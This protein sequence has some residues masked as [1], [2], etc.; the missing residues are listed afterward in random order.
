MERTTLF[1][2]QLIKSEICGKPISAELR[3]SIGTDDVEKLYSLSKKH[4]M[5]HLV[6]SALEHAELTFDSEYA[7]KLKIQ[8]LLATFRYAQFAH[9]FRSLC[10]VLEEAGIQ[11]IPLKGSVMRSYYPEPWMRTSCDIDILVREVDLERAKNI[12]VSKL[13]YEAGKVNSHDIGMISPSGVHFELHYSLIEE[14]EFAAFDEV[15]KNV[16][17]YAE[18]IG[19]SEY[20]CRL[21]DSMFYY[22]HTAHM[23]KH[24]MHGGCGIR[25]LAD[26]IL[27]DTEDAD[28]LRERESLLSRGGLST[29]AKSALHLARVWFSDAE[30]T[31]LTQQ[32]ERLILG[33]GVYGN[34]E[35]YVVIQQSKRGGKFRYAISR[36]WLPYDDLRFY[37]PSLNGRRWLLPFYEVKRWCR[38]IFSKQSRKR[39]VAELRA[40]SNVTDEDKMFIQA[41]LK[42]LEL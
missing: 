33:G 38:L 29:F 12:I 31:D 20:H 32:M 17:Q 5:A 34:R 18:P 10:S 7:K 19:G 6:A 24:Y 40:T 3:D 9:E 39:S 22:Y 21:S 8:K 1:L 35:N 26:L 42:Q 15:L 41:H 13:E 2:M 30:H 36:I 37:Y 28:I 4:D 27:L 14:D 11:F 23:A 16:W 25:P